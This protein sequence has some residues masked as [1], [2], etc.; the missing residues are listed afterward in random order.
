[1]LLL[2]SSVFSDVVPPSVE[3]APATSSKIDPVRRLSV[4]TSA[5]V[6]PVSPR[7]LSSSPANPAE[8][9]RSA[10]V[11]LPSPPVALSSTPP[12]VAP[13]SPR[14]PSR[15]LSL[16]LSASQVLAVPQQQTGAP[17]QLSP[18]AGSNRTPSMYLQQPATPMFQQQASQTSGLLSPRGPAVSPR[19]GSASQPVDSGRA[20]L[21]QSQ[22]L[23]GREPVITMKLPLVGLAVELPPAPVLPAQFS[24]RGSAIPP[25]LTASHSAPAVTSPARGSTL[26]NVIP[27]PITAST[28]TRGPSLN[29]TSPQRSRAVTATAPQQITPQRSRTATATAPQTS[30]QRPRPTVLPAGVNPL[31]LSLPSVGGGSN[32]AGQPVVNAADLHGCPVSPLPSLSGSSDQPQYSRPSIAVLLERP[33]RSAVRFWQPQSYLYWRPGNAAGSGNSRGRCPKRGNTGSAFC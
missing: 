26:P 1:M 19:R 12:A 7:Q 10:S 8:G 31:A 16:N 30:P 22:V 2:L 32:R 9:S 14:G 3:S 4:S 5:P 29:Q 20:G 33:A 21:S 18:R 6:L 27:P 13:L 28:S 23:P 25:P 24:P 11:L 15:P 17:G